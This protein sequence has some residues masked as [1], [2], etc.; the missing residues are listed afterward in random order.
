VSIRPRG[1]P[2]PTSSC[3]SFFVSGVTVEE[4]HEPTAHAVLKVEQV[5]M[6]QMTQQFVE[7]PTVQEVVHEVVQDE[8]I[9]QEKI[10]EIP[11][12]VQRYKDVHALAMGVKP[13]PGSSDVFWRSAEEIPQQTTHGRLL[14]R[15]PVGWAVRSGG[16]RVVVVG[17][18]SAIYVMMARVGGTRRSCHRMSGTRR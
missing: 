5:Q 7:I 1:T 6:G 14:S 15:H 4:E 16:P 10:M 18:T 2:L 8:V 3:S 17:V 12:H 13:S 9:Q 11:Q